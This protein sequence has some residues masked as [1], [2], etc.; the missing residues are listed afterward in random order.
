M[1]DAPQRLVYLDAFQNELPPDRG[2]IVF[3]SQVLPTPNTLGYEN[4]EHLVVSKVNGVPIKSLNDLAKAAKSFQRMVST[5]SSSRKIRPSFTWMP[6]E[7]EK[8]RGQLMQDY[9]IPALENLS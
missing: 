9:G 2:K 8:S 5:R 6:S 3:L 7:I 4:L 1:K